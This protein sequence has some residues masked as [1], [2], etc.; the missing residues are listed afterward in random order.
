[1]S[2]YNQPKEET[3]ISWIDDKPTG[4]PAF[5]SPQG[6]ASG[7][8]RYVEPAITVGSSLAAEIP[9]GWAGLAYRDPSMVERVHGDWTYQPRSEAGREGLAD[10]GSALSGLGGVA[11][12][13]PYLGAGIRNFGDSKDQL[14]EAGY[15]GAAAALYTAPA[16]LAMMIPGGEGLR[17]MAKAERGITGVGKKALQEMA[18]GP[19][20]RGPMASQ[21]G[22]I[23][24]SAFGAGVGR[25]VI[26]MTRKSKAAAGALASERAAE[27]VGTGMERTHQAYIAEKT[28]DKQEEKYGRNL[29]RN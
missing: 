14:I 15:P 27:R 3:G 21:G 16:A 12:D 9:A 11:M 18:K 25:N 19:S 24:P 20:M 5:F 4:V 13:I 2:S 28:A 29:F 22:F 1:M 7:I 26:Q 23:N 8:A 6:L 10:L 17:A